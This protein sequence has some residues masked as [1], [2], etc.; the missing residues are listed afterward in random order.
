MVAGSAGACGEGRAGQGV[1][2]CCC[3]LYQSCSVG[4]FGG[5][6]G[7][8]A[9]LSMSVCHN[10]ILQA[11]QRGYIESR[12]HKPCIDSHEFYV[13]ALSAWRFMCMAA[14]Q[15]LEL[16]MYDLPACTIEARHKTPKT[17]PRRSM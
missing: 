5:V 1:V 13:A 14:V 9:R 15:S 6:S 17:S 12:E 10:R 4:A 8:I 16:F 11:C 3:Y 2:G 7:Q